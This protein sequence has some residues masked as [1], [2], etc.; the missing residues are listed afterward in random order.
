MVFNSLNSGNTIEIMTHIISWSSF[1]NVFLLIQYNTLQ[2]FQDASIKKMMKSLDSKIENLT[3]FAMYNGN[4]NKSFEIKENIYDYVIKEYGT[5]FETYG[6]FK[7]L[8]S[9]NLINSLKRVN[10]GCFSKV[11]FKHFHDLA[12][13]G[14][15][16]DLFSKIEFE[17]DKPKSN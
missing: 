16:S 9:T 14:G 13:R 2:I 15:V 10:F 8:V 6:I 5:N 17:I 4:Y 11:D 12:E 3:I 7:I 1:P